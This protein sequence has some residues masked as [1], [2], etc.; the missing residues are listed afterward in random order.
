MKGMKEN[1]LKVIECRDTRP[2][3]KRFFGLVNKA[4]Y[5]EFDII[6]VAYPGHLDMFAAKIISLIKKKPIIFDAFIS[7]YDTMINEWKF[8]TRYSPKGIYYH[9]LDRISCQLANIVLLDTEQHIDYFV[10]EFNLK[11][12][13]FVCI[14]IGADEEIFHP[15]KNTRISDKFQILYYGHTNPLH[16]FPYIVEAAKLLENEKDIEFLL[17]GDKR[18][19]R[20]E[21]DRN[22]DLKNVKF[23]DAV[24]FRE[25]ASYIANADICL[26]IFGITIKAQNVIPNKAYE[27]IAMRKPLITGNTLAAKSYF[28]NKENA[29]LC[30]VGS[31][32]AIV[33][34]I[35]LLKNNQKLREKISENGYEL[36]KDNF[37]TK[38]IGQQMKNIIYK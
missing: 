11:R 26:G 37:T 30:K 23:Y 31:A 10:K 33:E 14:P 1:D 17:I 20:Y 8:G 15:C 28:K 12:S 7:T 25:I 21:R 6:F 18:W 2:I 27:I 19:F 4:I 29:I 5:K 32:H 38:K 13:K 36:F 24:L 9:L 3:I 16:G 34:S 35:L 22:K